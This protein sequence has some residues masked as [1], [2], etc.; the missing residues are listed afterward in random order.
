MNLRLRFMR[1]NSFIA[2]LKAFLLFSKLLPVG[3]EPMFPLNKPE[4]QYHPHPQLLVQSS[5][6]T[7]N[8]ALVRDL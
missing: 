5:I 4:A 6:L 3:I 2:S 8:S 7:E 1:L